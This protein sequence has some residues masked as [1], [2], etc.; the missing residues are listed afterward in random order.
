MSFY[1]RVFGS[2]LVVLA[3]LILGKEYSAY[4]N[5]RCSESDGFLLFLLH[6]KGE[7]S[8][9]LTPPDGF[10]RS[11]EN[12][13]LSRTGFL[14]SLAEGVGLKDAFE[15]AKKKL[16][17]CS[18]AQKCLFEFFSDFGKDYKD[19]ELKRCE[20]YTER[21]ESI[22]RE[23]KC[24]LEK[25]VRVVRSILCAVALGIVILLI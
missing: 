11:F 15:L 10:A 9:F 23:D 7:V 17:L 24:T 19:G 8:R 21:F 18:D 14:T 1:L 12:D 3:A 22:I 6:I 4:V 13:A 16:S 20:S 2:V 5:K 25:N